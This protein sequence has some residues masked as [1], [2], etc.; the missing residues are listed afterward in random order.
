MEKEV[1][2]QELVTVVTS[3]KEFV[4][5][6]KETLEVVKGR[7]IELD[8]VEEQLKRQVAEALGTSVDALQRVLNTSVGKLTERGDTL[9]TVVSALK[10]QIENFKGEL[11]ICKVALG[12]DV[13]AVIPKLKVDAFKPKEFKGAYR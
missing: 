12:N 13:L 1:N 3:L 7:T 2:N 10:E 9:D 11:V 4:G 5:G 6:M 8:L